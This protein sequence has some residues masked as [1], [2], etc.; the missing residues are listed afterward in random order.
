MV[1]GFLLT[2]VLV[3]NCVARLT[4][5]NGAS[6][7]Y[8]LQDGE[9]LL[10]WSLGYQPEQGDIVVLN[11]T[12]AEF[13]GG[14]GGE[15]IVKRVIATGGQSVDID[16]VTSTVYVDG[17]PLDEPYI[18]EAMSLNTDLFMQNTHWDVPEGSIFVM[19]DNRNAS[20]DSRHDLLG[21]IDCGY[22]LGK[23]VLALWPLDQIG[24]F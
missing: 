3:F 16:Y 20:T 18:K 8:T 24:V 7:D 10:L 15:A 11:K 2:V 9:M 22:I 19:G 12:T 23:V 14:E 21:C 6:M 17:Q 4:R 5:V 13:L 1:L